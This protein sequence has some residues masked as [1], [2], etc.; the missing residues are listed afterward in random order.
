MGYI[1]GVKQHSISAIVENKHTDI[2]VIVNCSLHLIC[3]DTGA[4]VRSDLAPLHAVHANALSD[5]LILR[6]K[7]RKR[8]TD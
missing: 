8:Q 6:R 3:T 5:E 1:L 7:A 2:A 4:H